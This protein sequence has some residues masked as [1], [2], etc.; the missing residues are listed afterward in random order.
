M[1]DLTK[2]GIGAFGNRPFP[3]ISEEALREFE[4]AFDVSLPVSDIQFLRFANGGT[5]KVSDYDDPTTGG[6]GGINDFYG[7]GSREDDERALSLGKWDYGNLWGETRIFSKVSPKLGIPFARDGGDNQL[8][9]AY[10][11][12]IVRVSRLIFASRTCYR[13]AQSFEQFLDLLQVK[14]S[15]PASKG[16]RSITRAVRLR[17]P[18]EE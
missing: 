1:R 10:S 13:I 6:R 4:R 15:A 18:K 7:L 12:E 16:K 2:L 14:S 5:L 8:F 3:S 11:E 9:L 17:L